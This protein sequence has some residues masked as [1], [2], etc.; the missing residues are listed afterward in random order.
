MTG[1]I[2][3]EIDPD[4]KPWA[5]SWLLARLGADYLGNVVSVG[6][7]DDVTDEVLARVR[8]LKHLHEFRIFTGPSVTDGD[9]EYI[10]NLTSVRILFLNRTDVT[11]RGLAHLE[12]LTNLQSLSLYANDQIDS[13][14]LL[15][16]RGLIKL[17][18]LDFTSSFVT[19]ELLTHLKVLGRLQHLNL[20][21]RGHRRF[22]GA[23]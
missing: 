13:D 17:R 5:P 18:E 20:T 21:T 7:G 22:A 15:Y 8:D 19:D 1:S 11:D 12:G 23:S 10:K 6:L 2:N 14:G 4:G 16:L 9:L 3:G